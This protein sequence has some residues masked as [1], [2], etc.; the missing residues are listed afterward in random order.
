MRKIST[1]SQ[2]KEGVVYTCAV[3][4]LN[5]LSIAYGMGLFPGYILSCLGGLV[6][7]GSLVSWRSQVKAQLFF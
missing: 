3:H 1:H 5:G 7:S 2:W 6:V 4:L